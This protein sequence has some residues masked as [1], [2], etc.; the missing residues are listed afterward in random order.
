MKLVDVTDASC[1]LGKLESCKK[2]VV[3]GLGIE[4]WGLSLKFS[5]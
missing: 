3:W 4:D 5:A 1:K 2:L